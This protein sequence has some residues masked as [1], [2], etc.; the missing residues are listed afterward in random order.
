MLLKTPNL[1]ANMH[2]KRSKYALKTPKHALKNSKTSTTNS[3]TVFKK[4]AKIDKSFST[5]KFVIKKA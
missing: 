1:H 2:L 3:K 4:K 5:E